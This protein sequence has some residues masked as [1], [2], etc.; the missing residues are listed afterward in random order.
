MLLNLPKSMLF[1]ITKL[2]QIAMLL[3]HSLGQRQ[4]VSK[5]T[6][7]LLKELIH[8]MQVD[9]MSNSIGKLGLVKL[10]K[11]K[12]ITKFKQ[13]L[14]TIIMK[15]MEIL[16]MQLVQ[17]FRLK[18]TKAKLTDKPATMTQQLPQQTK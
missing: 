2:V 8:N 16:L 11:S 9:L 3:N 15:L 1:K 6:V 4:S 14:I 5:E 12:R 7:L 13:I 18:I 17:V 10:Q